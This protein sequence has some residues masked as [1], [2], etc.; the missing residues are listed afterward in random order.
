M[1]NGFYKYIADNTISYFYSI[2]ESIRPGE[3]YS[4]ILDNEELVAGVVAALKEKTALDNMQGVYN[5]KDKYT[6]FTIKISDSKQIVV[7]AKSSNVTDSFLAKL[8]NTKLTEACYPILI[9]T[10]DTIDTI[11]S[12]TANM[13]AAG[14]PFNSDTIMENLNH[15]I[16]NGQLSLSD[17]VILQSELELKKQDRYN[18]KTSLYEYQDILIALGKGT[19]D[20]KDYYRFSLFP[21]PTIKTFTDSKKIRER[22]V[23]NRETFEQIDRIFKRGNIK[24]RLEKE[25]D[26]EFINSIIDRKKKSLPWHEDYTYDAVKA[27]KEKI[28]KKTDN[29]LIIENSGI[30]IYSGSPVEYSFVI[31]D[32]AFI[33]SDGK[34]KAAERK[35]S[36]LIYNFDNREEIT[37]A[38]ATNIFIKKS[39]IDYENANVET[40]AR[41]ILIKVVP[42]DGCYFSKAII[43]DTT[44]NIKYEIKVC[45]LNTPKTYLDAI[46]TAYYLYVSEKRHKSKIQVSGFDEKIVINP[47]QEKILEEKVLKDGEEYSCAYDET[48]TLN[49]EKEQI[50][51]DTGKIS[52]SLKC[53]GTSIPIELQDEPVKPV[54]LTGIAAFKKKFTEKRCL[55]YKNEPGKERIIAGTEEFYPKENRDYLNIE[56]EIISNRWMYARQTING[57]EGRKLHI[58]Q[59]IITAY[60]DL[61]ICLESQKTVPSLAYYKGNLLEIAK[62][63]VQLVQDKIDSI[64]P[65]KTLSMEDNEL[66]L[67]G[68]VE[69]DTNGKLIKMSPLHPLNVMYQLNLLEE[70]QVGDVREVLIEKLTPLYLIPYLF[71]D[72]KQ[73]FHSVEQK[74]APEWRLYAPFADKRYQG[75]RSFVKKLVGEKITGYKEYFSFLFEDIGNRKMLI[76][77]VNMGDCREVLSG[78]IA[79]YVKE[80]KVKGV[81]DTSKF[82]FNIYTD[83]NVSNCFELL[84]DYKKLKQYIMSG[85]V[86]EKDDIDVND[87]VQT[88]INNVEV[89]YRKLSE[90]S[91]Q[92]AHVTFYEMAVSEDCGHGQVESINTGV[93]LGGIVSGMPSVLNSD[94]YK[95]GF[96]MKY[97]PEN[98]IT[99]MAQLYNAMYRV[100]NTGSAYEP[101]VCLFTE[102]EKNQESIRDKIYKSSNWVVFVDPKV[103]LTFFQRGQN[104]DNELMIIHYSDQYT[105]SNGYDDITVTQKSE[106]YNDI[107]HE[108]LQ[109]KGVAATREDINKIISLFNA[110]NGSWMLRLITS[111]KLSGAADSNFSREKMSILSAI[112]LSMGYYKHSNIVW[113]PISLEEMLRVSG[114]AGYSQKEGLL[115][116][117]NL[118]FATQATSDDILLVG[119][120]EKDQQL[121]IYLHPVEVKIGQNPQGVLDKAKLQVVNT[122][123]GLWN[124]LWPEENRDA[125]ESKLSRNFFMQ[126]V[127]VCAEKMKLYNVYPEVKW[128]RVIDEW[129]MRLLNEDYVISDDLDD[130]IGKGTIISFKSDVMNEYGDMQDD[131]CVLQYPEKKGSSFM[132]M[133]TDEIE[134][135]VE[136]SKDSLPVR[137]SQM[138][139]CNIQTDVVPEVV[140]TDDINVRSEMEPI[141]KIENNNNVEDRIDDITTMPKVGIEV[142]FGKDLGSGRDLIWKP[143]DTEQVF[144]T[145]TGII[146]TMGTGK[147]Q[148]TKSLI[149]QLY[150]NQSHNVAAKELGI[151]IFDYKGDYN[152]SKMDFVQATNATILKPYHLPFN[153]LA[154]TKSAVVKPLLPLHTANAFKDTIS[155]VYGLGPKQE[156]ALLECMLGAYT[157]CGINPYDSST[158]DREE[159]TFDQVY[160][161]YSNDEDI[162]KGDSLASAMNKLHRFQIFES[163]PENTKGLYDLLN[164]V[165][166]IDLSGYDDDIQSL[167]VAITLDLFYSQMQA[168]GSSKLDGQYRQLTKFILVDEADNFMSQGFDALKKILK[169]GREFGVGTI[170]STQFLKHFG[171]DDDDYSKYILT[172]VVH[173]VADLKN[174]DVDFV[175][176][177]E[178]KSPQS[179]RLFNDIKGLK[180]HHSIVKIGNNNPVYIK[181]KAFWELMEE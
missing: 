104:E 66:L 28:K 89:F 145:N 40:S 8:R 12:G 124:A 116:A 32:K 105:S 69:D 139:K 20:T 7:A 24:E 70:H 114:G 57:L 3:R 75:T 81:E 41:E 53:G 113:V 79:Y 108:Q 47:E 166:V 100:A 49:I 26:K 151:L 121:N 5:Y 84:G 111:K 95:T 48:L 120:E 51:Q 35:K 103:D 141:E 159:P 59:D 134:R 14:M 72:K 56:K 131:V 50:N 119:I 140:N 126:L 117:R 42:K 101:K 22:L 10:Y 63:Y 30:E 4:L 98:R 68:C 27:S 158:W 129:R 122:Y 93:S 65:H 150:K 36:I 132:V 162:K 91:F 44:N 2:R 163:N 138:Y 146:G 130:L 67:L 64:E 15:Q 147:T 17:Q 33:R 153:P 136:A 39:D 88:L 112:K 144:H 23:D 165:V 171:T 80:I 173:N 61:C 178:S 62:R 46:K 107:I 170:L 154:L 96:G 97:A 142:N 133:S 181:D 177:T 127:I 29:P 115:S 149:T 109:K 60:E 169:E 87:V 172:W 179:V 90:E 31:D 92:Y 180:K 54:V 128:E 102:I 157:R 175:F 167:I 21:D 9:I 160:Q 152:E 94:W 176:K 38:V 37:V 16:M 143:N 86:K 71:N 156:D 76:N 110:I 137:L 18:D 155:K 123:E 45:I 99:K 11:I 161:I 34:T 77:L 73:L 82:A 13:A 43:N 78:L 83:E 164:G 58:S 125:L 74:D 174:N 118:G 19:I 135:Q 1:S 55:E 85:F 25:F 148:F 168:S 52:F 106:Q 6:T